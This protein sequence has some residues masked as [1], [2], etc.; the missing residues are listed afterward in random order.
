MK[1]LYWKIDDWMTLNQDGWSTKPKVAALVGAIMAF[2]PKTVLEIGIWSGKS[3]IPMAMAMKHLGGERT[4]IGLDPWSPGES[5]QGLDG[6]HLK[7]WANVDHDRIYKL[8]NDEMLKYNLF[9]FCQVYRCR[10]DEWKMPEDLK[11]DLLHVDG[12]HGEQAAVY[13]VETF[14]PKVRVGGL[15]WMDDVNWAS[16]ASREIPEMGFQFLFEE[17]GGAMYQRITQI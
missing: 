5:V 3:F 9:P 6:D 8:F 10:S 13:D 2:R 16:A 17:D 1:E 14:C 12:N 15:C 11:L 4:L 7:W